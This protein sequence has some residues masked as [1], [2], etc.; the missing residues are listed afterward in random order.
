[1]ESLFQNKVAEIKISYQPKQSP[2]QRP[3]LNR[4][5]DAYFQFLEILDLSM[6]NIK[7]EA[8]V[9]YLN[10]GNR[11]IGAYKLSSGGIT[12]TIVDI[13]IILAIALKGLASGIII[14]HTHPSGE[15]K[16][17]KAD[18][19][20]TTRLKEAAKLMEISLHDH[21]IITSEAFFSFA[22]DGII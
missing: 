5:E 7:E 8:A 6:L 11:M 22:D 15:L 13:R 18:L 20:L 14:A 4:P 1:M 2:I 10:R 17:S 12:G 19:E 9:I 3:K 16:P 21:L